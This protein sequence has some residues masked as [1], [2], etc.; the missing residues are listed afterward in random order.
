MWGIDPSGRDE[1]LSLAQ[2]M[3]QYVHE[4]LAMGNTTLFLDVFPLHVFYKERGLEALETCL[5]SRKN[6]YGQMS[7]LCYG[8]S[9]RR[10]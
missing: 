5:A 4:M 9:S 1:S 2:Q 3:Y 10:R 7:T 6:I 8:P